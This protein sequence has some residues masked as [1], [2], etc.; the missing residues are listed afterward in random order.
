[1]KGPVFAT[2]VKDTIKVKDGAEKTAWNIRE[3]LSTPKGT[4]PCLPT[5]GCNLYKLRFEL[6]DDFF[7]DLCKI[8]ITDAINSS[9]SGV[10]IKDIVV[11]KKDRNAVSFKILFMDEE[12]LTLGSYSLSFN[13]GK[14]NV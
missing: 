9:L 12:S 13:N 1:M 6:I 2:S 5:F 14:W 7:L 4:R 8:Y 3:V 11:E 10:T